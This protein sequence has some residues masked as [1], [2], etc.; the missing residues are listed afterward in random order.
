MTALLPPI[1][2]NDNRE[3]ELQI[4]QEGE[5]KSLGKEA[6]DADARTATFRIEDWNDQRDVDYRLVYPLKLANGSTMDYYWPGTVRK[7]PK[8]KDDF[9]LAAFC[10]QT[11]YG[12]PHTD[13]LNNLAVQNPDLLFFA[14][15][16][17][18]EHVGGYGIIRFPGDRAILN[19]L[20]K[21]YLFGWAFG[22]VMRS[23]PTLC[24][25]DDHDVFQGNVWGNG[26]NAVSVEDHDGGGFVEPPEMVNVVH[27]HQYGPPSRFLRSHAD[28]TK[29]QRLLR[30]HALRRRKFRPRRRPYV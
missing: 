3:V 20:R 22:D 7:D 21:F 10:C 16:Q 18:Y 9:V 14:G 26:G 15:D 5:W 1:G 2:D 12:F 8:E 23:R 11:D 13:M 24:L 4:K 17:I 19:Y 29:H 28:P 27:S 25:P 30:R 6:I